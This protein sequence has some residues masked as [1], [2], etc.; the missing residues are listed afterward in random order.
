MRCPSCGTENAP[1]SR[2][3]GG[4]GARLV[5]EQR[6]APT[7]KISDDAR[8]DSAQ[9]SSPAAA[10]TPTSVPRKHPG[11]APPGT[12]QVPVRPPTS[13]VIP[14]SAPR[15]AMQPVP[16]MPMSIPPAS[17]APRAG[18]PPARPST[19]PM[20]RSSGQRIVPPAPPVRSSAKSLEPPRSRW[21]LILLVLL[22]DIGLAAA[23]VVLLREGLR[24]APATNGSGSGSNTAGGAQV[25]PPKPPHPDVV[26]EH[27]PP[28]EDEP[29]KHEELAAPT[30]I[31]GR[32]S[33]V[34][35]DVPHRLD[36]VDPPPTNRARTQVH[37]TTRKQSGSG[38]GP[39]DPYAGASEPPP[40]IS[41]ATQ[42]DR[43]FVHSKPAFDGCYTAVSRSLPP[44]QAPRGTIKIAFR[45]IPDG[46]VE[47]VI[48]VEN[49]TGSEPLAGCLISEIGAWVLPAHGGDGIDFVRAVN[50]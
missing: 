27:K 44:D 38:S 7:H 14:V 46:R 22:I 28:S 34:K 2:F 5:S 36:P 31:D 16:Q 48:A 41:L 43:L 26:V 1:D 17:S 8:W 37:V 39:V 6:V 10:V 35:T 29:L 40:A 4:C 19:A 50:F 23:G 30:P 21:G 11:S 42:V 12:Y 9:P 20:Q 47:R 49:G 3:C 25:D 18:D 15:S 32:G 24:E 13:P 33:V 45:V